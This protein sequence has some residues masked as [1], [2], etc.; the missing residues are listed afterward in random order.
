MWKALGTEQNMAA[1]PYRRKKKKF[2]KF[3]PGGEQAAGRWSNL[4]LQGMAAAKPN[5][6]CRHP[7]RWIVGFCFR[8]VVRWFWGTCIP[9]LVGSGRFESRETFIYCQRVKDKGIW[10][11]KI[12]HIMGKRVNCNNLKYPRC[13][14]PQILDKCD[15]I[16]F[17]LVFWPSLQNIQEYCLVEKTKSKLEP[18]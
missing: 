10:T 6:G 18:V 4:L 8:D 5:R 13:N 12:V 3:K 1:W 15:I 11:V 16:A 17:I 9:F 14:H 2:W 7:T